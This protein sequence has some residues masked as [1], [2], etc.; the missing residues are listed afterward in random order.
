MPWHGQFIDSSSLCE[1]SSRRPERSQASSHTG[2]QR[3]VRPRPSKNSIVDEAPSLPVPGT[4][5]PGKL[6]ATADTLSRAPATTQ[7]ASLG[8][9]SLDVERFVNNI[10]RGWQD[11]AAP[12]LEQLR[13]HQEGDGT[14]MDLARLCERGWPRR[15]SLVPIHLRCFWS[16]RSN[17]TVCEGLLLY[18]NRILVPAALRRDMLPRL[19][20]GHQGIS[21]SQCTGALVRVVAD[22]QLGTR[23]TGGWLCNLCSNADTV[24]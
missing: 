23:T 16:T 24:P 20:E 9:D 17:I 10:V 3:R 4:R 15:A 13:K 7:V 19:H 2:G 21:R 12:G 11:L 8:V 22:P 1:I 5:V 14:C 6:I 18:N